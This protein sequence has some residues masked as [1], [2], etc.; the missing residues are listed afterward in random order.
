MTLGTTWCD[1]ALIWFVASGPPLCNEAYGRKSIEL[2]GEAFKRQVMMFSDGFSWLQKFRLQNVKDNTV[3][4]KKKRFY[5]SLQNS[6]PKP[7]K[8]QE[9]SFIYNISF[10]AK[11]KESVE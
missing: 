4:K 8:G 11:L 1:L 7:R 10:S 6:L 9:I 5:S 3:R 2:V